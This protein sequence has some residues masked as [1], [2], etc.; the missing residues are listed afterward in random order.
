MS[1]CRRKISQLFRWRSFHSFALS[2]LFSP[3]SLWMT[4]LEVV[5]HHFFILF[6]FWRKNIFTSRRRI[7][8]FRRRRSMSCGI[9]STFSVVRRR[10]RCCCA[11][12]DVLMRRRPWNVTLM[13]R[14]W[15][16]L[17]S[18]N[19]W[20][21]GGTPVLSESCAHSANWC[22][23]RFNTFF[24]RNR[25][26]SRNKLKC[27]LFVCENRYVKSDEGLSLAC[28]LLSCVTVDN[29]QVPHVDY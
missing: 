17:T 27:S 18:N 29:S 5:F 9:S 4:R 1:R 20:I 24:W 23:F 16:P 22:V 10:V 19:G 26:T 11:R 15:R 12:I 14:L 21:C 28:L 7:E 6:F 13:L 8:G 3:C 2:F 25:E